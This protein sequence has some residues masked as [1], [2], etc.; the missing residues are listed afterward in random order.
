VPFA[1]TSPRVQVSV[2]SV[3]VHPVPDN[4]VAVKLAGKVSTTLT[5]PVVAVLP[6]LVT[7]IV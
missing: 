7:V 6:L 2:P 5:A 4:P 3:Q 1:S